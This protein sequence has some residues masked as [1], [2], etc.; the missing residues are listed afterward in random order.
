MS[1]CWTK[2]RQHNLEELLIQNG[3]TVATGVKKG[4]TYLV[5]KDPSGSSNKLDKARELGVEVISPDD[6]IYLFKSKG[7]KI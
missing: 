2:V 3:G 6:M 7:I 4:L 1:V 5:A